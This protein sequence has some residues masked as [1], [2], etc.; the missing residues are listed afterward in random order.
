MR[1]NDV[2][3]HMIEKSSTLGI[4]EREAQKRLIPMA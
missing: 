1:V 2:V 3:D 4:E